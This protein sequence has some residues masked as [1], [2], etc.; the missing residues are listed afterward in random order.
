M[1]HTSELSDYRRADLHEASPS[2]VLPGPAA[3]DRFDKIAA[4]AYARWESLRGSAELPSIPPHH[5]EES[6]LFTPNCV[7]VTWDE[8]ISTPTISY[9]GNDLA[10][11]LANLSGEA[12]PNLPIESPLV[13]LL[14]DIS[15]QA[16]REKDAMEFEEQVTDSEGW[17]RDCQGL[18]LPFVGPEIGTFLVDVLFDLDNPMPTIARSGQGSAKSPDP[19]DVLLLEQEFD[20][21]EMPRPAIGPSPP[22]VLFVC[23][24]D[25]ESMPLR[26]PRKPALT[27]ES[28]FRS[29]LLLTEPLEL[30][31]EMIAD[32]LPLPVATATDQLLLSLEVARDR[33]AAAS[34]SEERSH[35]ALYRA[36]GAAYDFARLAADAPERLEQI[37]QEAGLKV[38]TRAPMTPVAKLIFGADHDRSRLAEYA[39]ALSYALRLGLPAGSFADYLLTFEGGLKG[40]IQAERQ[41]RNNAEPVRS[42]RARIETRLR[43]APVRTFDDLAPE[44]QE[45]AIIIARR[46]PGGGVSLIGEVPPDDRLFCSVTRKFLKK[47]P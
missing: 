21:D 34:S 40:V 12:W 14:H 38:Q 26:A 29:P 10:G 37:I 23:V 16:V 45:F 2:A 24:S 1:K 20:P 7:Q 18:A 35:V 33:A 3:A 28:P 44:G 9:L 8:D 32:P 22:P 27:K 5:A 46:L 6:R 25:K 19:E 15:A 41:L 39:S 4:L 42:R 11:Q 31:P 30:Q 47:Q 17:I 43:K 36:I 13:T